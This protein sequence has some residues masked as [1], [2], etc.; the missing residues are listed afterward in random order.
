MGEG[1]LIV[2]QLEWNNEKRTLFLIKAGPLG[3]IKGLVINHLSG[4]LKRLCRSGPKP[5]NGNDL[6]MNPPERGPVFRP[7]TAGHF[8]AVLHRDMNLHDIFE[9][10]FH[11]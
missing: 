10:Y 11:N 5:V 3:M 9:V 7:R 4:P 8:D 2:F 1:G 6:A